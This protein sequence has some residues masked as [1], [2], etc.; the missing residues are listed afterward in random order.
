MLYTFPANCVQHRFRCYTLILQVLYSNHISLWQLSESIHS[1]FCFRFCICMLHELFTRWLCTL[2]KI[3][4]AHHDLNGDSDC[5][6]CTSC[7]D[8]QNL[9]IGAFM[10]LVLCPPSLHF[11]GSAIPLFDWN[12]IHNKYVCL[13][14]FI[15]HFSVWWSWMFLVSLFACGQLEFV[16]LL[17]AWESIWMSSRVCCMMRGRLNAGCMSQLMSPNNLLPML[18]LAPPCKLRQYVNSFL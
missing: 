8:L 13:F 18:R 6:F 1:L 5:G 3:I 2:H 4:L 17:Q 15:V 12:A 7:G 10:R 9:S 16:S 14:H 11:H